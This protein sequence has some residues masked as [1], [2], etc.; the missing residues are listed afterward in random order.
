MTV[1]AGQ[2]DMVVYPRTIPDTL[3]LLPTPRFLADSRR[4]RRSYG[5]AWE[6]EHE[7]RTTLQPT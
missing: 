1:G 2:T 4:M 5:C 7:G 3:A 6:L